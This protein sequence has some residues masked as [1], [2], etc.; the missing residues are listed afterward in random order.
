MPWL[1]HELVSSVTIGTTAVFNKQPLFK[2]KAEKYRILCENCL[3]AF[4]VDSV[5][6][7]A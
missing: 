2:T 5:L 6:F 4:Q 3:V 1:Y 7:H